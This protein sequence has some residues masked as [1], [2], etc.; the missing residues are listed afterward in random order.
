MTSAPLCGGAEKGSDL[1]EEGMRRY[2]KH[3]GLKYLDSHT[4][5]HLGYDTVIMDEGKAVRTREF[6]RQILQMI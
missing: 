2:C 6:A 4:E 5:R 3:S 1:F